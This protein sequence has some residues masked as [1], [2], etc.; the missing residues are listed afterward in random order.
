MSNKMSLVHRLSREDAGKNGKHNSRNGKGLN[1]PH[2]DKEKSKYNLYWNCLEKKWR[3]NDNFEKM[4][5]EYYNERFGSA[6]KKQNERHK[7]NGHSERCKTMSEFRKGRTTKPEEEL[8]QIGDKG[9]TVSAEVLL[10]VFKDYIDW[11]NKEFPEV[12]FLNVSLHVDE[13]C[14]PHIHTRR[15]WEIEKNDGTVEICEKEVLRRH[16]IELFDPNEKESQY[17]NRK[18]T[19]TKMTRDKLLEICLQHGLDVETEVKD[20][21]AKHLQPDA[22]KV[23]RKLEE[24][25]E[26][27]TDKLNDKEMQLNAVEITLD[28]AQRERL[29]LQSGMEQLSMDLINLHMLMIDNK[30]PAKLRDEQ[31][32]LTYNNCRK[33][34]DRAKKSGLM[35]DKDKEKLE[36]INKFTNIALD[37]IQ[38]YRH[39]F[40]LE[41][42]F[43]ND[44]FKKKYTDDFA[45]FIKL[46][47]EKKKREDEK[48]AKEVQALMK[49]LDDSVSTNRSFNSDCNYIDS[50]F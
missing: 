45:L 8:I 27:A 10:E 48:S 26:E 29:H 40:Y 18:M 21:K 30:V 4:E 23:K 9:N 3:N 36:D 5:K 44:Y 42:P 24:E 7:K 20:G 50:L 31:A 35:D 28:V 46:A 17:N 25:I 37:Y 1:R 19:Y 38:G 11:H 2:V 33:L 22:Y 41:D 13:E 39:D 34:R 47:D 32:Q 43:I 6:L 14:A 12:K 49:Q 16:N 15:L